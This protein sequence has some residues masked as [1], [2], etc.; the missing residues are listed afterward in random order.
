MRRGIAVAVMA[1]LFTVLSGYAALA[2]WETRFEEK[3]V[4]VEQGETISGDLWC[5]GDT[6]LIDGTVEGDLLVYANSLVVKGEVK[7]DILGMVLSDASFA[8]RIGGDLRL[9][10]GP[11]FTPTAKITLSCPVGGNISVSSNTF[12]MTRRASA[13][14]LW[15]KGAALT[16]NGRITG[17]VSYTGQNV[18]L[19]GEVTGA[20]TIKATDKFLVARGAKLGHIYYYQKPP[21]LAQAASVGPVKKLSLPKERPAY[22]ISPLVWIWFLGTLLMGFLFIQV[23]RSKVA[24]W[25]QGLLDWRRAL[26]LGILLLFGIPAG[27]LLL[28]ITI[29][30]APLAVL[31]LVLWVAVL[32]LS[33]IP[34]YLYLGGAVVRRFRIERPF[35]PGFLLL[36]GG[37]ITTFL[38]T[39]PFIGFIF[40]LL[41]IAFG[42]GILFQKPP[43][44]I[45]RPEDRG[46][47]A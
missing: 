47:V 33:P 41:A 10:G 6:V 46:S 29:V 12:T 23:Y 31:L 44:L 24:L 37:I 34:F 13:R 8:G 7:G 17:D 3:T 39:L 21:Q 4:L 30:G 11:F 26:L 38:T 2:A 16:M 19:G 18:L 22:A 32:V 28:L 43:V 15:G 9:L 27:V 5:A 14:G 1:V 42:L 25:V 36:V 40:N 20:S 35:S 45:L